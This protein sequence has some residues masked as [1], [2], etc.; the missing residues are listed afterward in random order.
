M[1]LVLKVALAIIPL[2]LAISLHEAA[3]GWAADKLGDATARMLG[4]LTANPLKHVDPVGTVLVPIMMFVILGFAFGWAK[5]VPVDVRNFKNPQKD[6]AL[7]ALAGPMANLIMAM[8]WTL[9]LVFSIKM[10]PQGNLANMLG[11]MANIGVVINLILMTL[12]LLP[13]PPLDGSRVLSGILPRNQ[14]IAFN[15]IEPYGMW[16]IIFLLVSGILGKILWP[17]V[18]AIQLTLYSILGLG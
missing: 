10:L 7:V 5:P 13:I 1:E 8:L 11:I 2:L 3:H 17:M 18:Q 12:N 15:K 16:I 6:M 9:L 4:R 14:A